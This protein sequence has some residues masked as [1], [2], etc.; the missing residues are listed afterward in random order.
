MKQQLVVTIRYSCAGI[1]RRITLHCLLALP[2]NKRFSSME[3]FSVYN[4]N[5][6]R[7]HPTAGKRQPPW[8]LYCTARLKTGDPL[9]RSLLLRRKHK[10]RCW[11][12]HVVPSLIHVN[13]ESLG[14]SRASNASRKHCLVNNTNVGQCHTTADDRQ[15][16]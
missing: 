4:T 7:C 10:I 16:F 8:W 5:V 11:H 2:V 14:A 9:S 6:D 13:Q 15:P 12:V 3:R 1:T